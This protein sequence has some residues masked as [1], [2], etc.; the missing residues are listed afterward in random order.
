MRMLHVIVPETD[1]WADVGNI[2]PEPGSRRIVTPI[3]TEEPDVGV[4]LYEAGEHAVVDDKR[5][6]EL[7]ESG[8]RY[9]VRSSVSVDSLVAFIR[10]MKHG[11]A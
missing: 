5:K 7:D 2:R 9:S 4:S 10:E 1:V 6:A 11:K 3:V 8:V